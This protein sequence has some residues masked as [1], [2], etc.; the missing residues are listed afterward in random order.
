MGS[1]LL[2]EAHAQA[3]LRHLQP[4]EGAL[5]NSELGEWDTPPIPL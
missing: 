3:H 5:R 4:V 1:A 2:S